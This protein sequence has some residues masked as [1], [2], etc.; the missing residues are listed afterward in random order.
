MD[1]IRI[2]IKNITDTDIEL[3][4]G[5]VFK[6]IEKTIITQRTD[7]DLLPAD[8]CDQYI[9]EK[10]YDSIFFYKNK[11]A[12]YKKLN[13]LSTN[14]IMRV[15]EKDKQKDR[16]GN[17]YKNLKLTDKFN[18]KK[19][20]PIYQDIT[21]ACDRAYD[22]FLEVFEKVQLD[23]RKKYPLSKWIEGSKLSNYF[24]NYLFTEWFEDNQEEAN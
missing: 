8:Y 21:E 18:L 22:D 7:H 20:F 13:E 11:W 17:K 6:Y 5:R 15:I 16:L 19:I 2:Q 23:P 9:L 14:E 1:N 4:D 10:T 24:Y 12:Y 3:Q